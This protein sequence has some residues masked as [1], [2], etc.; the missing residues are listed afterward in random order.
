MLILLRIH[1]SLHCRGQARFQ[2]IL[3]ARADGVSEWTLGER[4]GGTLVAS[5]AANL[6]R[7]LG[8]NLAAAVAPDRTPAGDP[9]T[10]VQ[11]GIPSRFAASRWRS[12]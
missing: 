6:V 11:R 7:T 12:S 8:R 9:H 2:S 3:S 1:V 5:L 10:Q 4:F